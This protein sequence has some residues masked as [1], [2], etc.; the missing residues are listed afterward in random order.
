M[1]SGISSF[2]SISASSGTTRSRTNRRVSD[3]TSANTAAS[4]VPP[5]GSSDACVSVWPSRSLPRAAIGAGTCPE[6]LSQRS[7]ADLADRCPQLLGGE[8]E[9][10][11]ALEPGQAL[12]AVRGQAVS[13][14][15]ASG[16]RASGPRASGGP[17]VHGLHNGLHLLAH[18]RVGNAENRGIEDLWVQGEHI[19]DLLRVDV[20]PA[21]DDQV[22]GPVGEVQ[23]AVP[24]EI[25]DV[26]HWPAASR[27]R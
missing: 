18:L 11:G 1:S 19:L 25:A 6:P 23:V 10:L 5:L 24:V 2:S 8:L 15:L 20:H 12:T 14:R 9:R 26:D 4:T 17:R 22:H 13:E 16:P 27:V 7:L 3:N 21:R